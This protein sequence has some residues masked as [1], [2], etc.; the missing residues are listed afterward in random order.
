MF[1]KDVLDQFRP[2]RYWHGL[3]IVLG[4][5]IVSGFVLA[6][7][8]GGGSLIDILTHEAQIFMSSR[9]PSSPAAREPT[10]SSSPTSPAIQSAPFMPAMPFGLSDQSRTSNG[11]PAAIGSNQ[12]SGSDVPLPIARPDPRVIVGKRDR[13]VDQTAEIKRQSKTTPKSIKSEIDARKAAAAELEQ[14]YADANVAITT[15]VSGLDGTVLNLRYPQFNDVTV[16]KIMGV[17]SFTTALAQVGFNKIIFTANENKMWSFP[18]QLPSPS[19]TATQG[20][21]PGDRTSNEQPDPG[22]ND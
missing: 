7:L 11:W 1:G 13:Y 17:N 16:K 6:I 21:A 10:K 9:L 8:T 19:T 22:S 14:D 18:L 4:I 20:A 3:T 2:R 15:R 12:A 5:C